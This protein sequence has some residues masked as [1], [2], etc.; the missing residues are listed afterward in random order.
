MPRALRVILY[1]A[2]DQETLDKQLAVNRAP[3]GPQCE[4][5]GHPRGGNLREGTHNLLTKITIKTIT[6]DADL[7]GILDYL[8]HY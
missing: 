3:D 4:K 2:K 7:L 6:D 5:C 8:E 1:E